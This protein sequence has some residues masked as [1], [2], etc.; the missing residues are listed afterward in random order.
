[1]STESFCAVCT[2]RVHNMTPT[3]VHFA[4]ERVLCTCIRVSVLWSHLG[5][6]LLLLFSTASGFI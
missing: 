3:R 2:N 6:D 4:Q 5:N 1:M